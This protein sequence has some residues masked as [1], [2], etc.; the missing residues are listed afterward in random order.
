MNTIAPENSRDRIILFTRFPKPGAVKTRLI[1]RLGRRGAAELHQKMTE[2]VIRQLQPILRERQIK[3]QVFFCGG[4]QRQMSDWL[5][6]NCTL[7]P[8]QGNDLGQR[9]NNA[10]N[11]TTRQAVERIVLIASD[12]PHLDSPIM[13]RAFMQLE[14]HDLVLGPAAD[15]GYY[16][17]GVR[18]GRNNYAPLFDNIE[19][20]TD[21]VLEQT[22][23]RADRT[24]LSSALLP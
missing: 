20:G 24:G 15:G 10:L 17:L 19:W 21:Q 3:L 14:S 5:G 8:Q 12:C 2:T 7:Q 9:M 16:L 6:D 23:N 13:A 4:T 18:S 22:L 1:D 11:L